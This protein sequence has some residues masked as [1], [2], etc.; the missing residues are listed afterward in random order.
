MANLFENKEAFDSYIDTRSAQMAKGFIEAWEKKHGDKLNVPAPVTP[1]EVISS[2]EAKK[3]LDQRMISHQKD[4]MSGVIVDRHF[5]PGLMQSEDYRILCTKW[6]RGYVD[7]DFRGTAEFRETCKRLADYDAISNPDRAKTI[8]SATG[9]AGAEFMPIGFESEIWHRVGIYNQMR[10]LARVLPVAGKVTLPSSA[11]RAT[12][13]YTAPATGPAGQ[14][15]LVSAS[16]TLDPH[17]LIVWDEVDKKL[18]YASSVDLTDFLASTFAEA[19]AYC[20]LDKFTNGTGTNQP[21]GF[22]NHTAYASV[23]A[24][25]LEVGLTVSWNDLINLEFTPDAKYRMF[26][27]YQL[28]TN[29]L[30]LVAKLKDSDERPIWSRPAEGRPGL[31]NGYPYVLNE[32]ISGTISI[33]GANTSEIYFGDWKS[34]VIGDMK[35]L[36]LEMSDQAGDAFKNDSVYV[37][38]VAYNDGELRDQAAIDYLTAVH[39]I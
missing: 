33:S 20:E 39:H 14:S 30:K 31:I 23:T 21:T 4:L 3:D 25:T 17:K 16:I 18:F 24:V 7:K 32:T 28:S 11:T 2:E 15:G 34:Y 38:M 27:V 1:G 6:V 22:A 8:D 26:G 19:I 13:Y 5:L 12:A 37:K 29:A 10:Q 36:G 9:A 35:K